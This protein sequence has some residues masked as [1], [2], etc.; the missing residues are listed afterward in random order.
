MTSPYR[1]LAGVIA[2]QYDTFMIA[3]VIHRLGFSDQLEAIM[4]AIE[5]AAM[6]ASEKEG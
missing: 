2:N 5:K 1:G 6:E 3:A 4:M